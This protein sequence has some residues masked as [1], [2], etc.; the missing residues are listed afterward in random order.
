MMYSTVKGSYFKKKP[1]YRISPYLYD[2]SPIWTYEIQPST[3]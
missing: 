1:T 3:F 2:Y